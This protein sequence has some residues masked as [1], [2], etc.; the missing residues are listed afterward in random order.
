M[1]ISESARFSAN[2]VVE[3]ET[4]QIKPFKQLFDSIKNKL[5]DTS[6]LFNQE[7][8]QI[9]QL[10][11]ASTFLVDVRLH[12]ENFEHFYCAPHDANFK[13]INLSAGHLNQVFKNV[14]NGDTRLV[15]YY[16]DRSDYVTIILENSSKSEHRTFEVPIQ[17]PQDDILLG[18]MKEF[19]QYGYAL[20]MPSADLVRI[21]RELKNMECEKVQITHDRRALRFVSNP[22]STNNGNVKTSIVRIGTLALDGDAVDA[23]IETTLFTKV[24][25][26]GHSIYS[27]TFKFATL[28]EF[29]KSQS[30]GENKIVRI[31]LQIDEPMILHYEIGTLGE[32]KVG[33]AAYVEG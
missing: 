14:T 27:G 26:D 31:F 32:L 23:D 21:C 29:S 9:L 13:E 25:T 33:L 1:G 24:P 19:D 10:D 17:N 15:L 16:E 5:P 3:I 20:S 22:G 30:G 11:S 2:S 6:L 28:Y 12:G 18:E 4:T 8:M 7:S